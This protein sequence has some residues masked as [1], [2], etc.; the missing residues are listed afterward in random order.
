MGARRNTGPARPPDEQIYA[1][2]RHVVLV[3]SELNEAI[4]ALRIGRTAEALAALEKLERT[5]P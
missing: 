5:W 4:T 1:A 3:R 2:A